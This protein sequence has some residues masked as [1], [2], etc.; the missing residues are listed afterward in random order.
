MMKRR[1]FFKTAGS[2]AVVLSAGSMLAFD[3]PPGQKEKSSA[4]ELKT[5]LDTYFAEMMAGKYFNPDHAMAGDRGGL[6][7]VKS[8]SLEVTT[9]K[10]SVF[11]I[12]DLV[13]KR[14][15]N[16]GF[17]ASLLKEGK[18]PE[19]LIVK[20]GLLNVP[21]SMFPIRID[22]LKNYDAAL[23]INECSIIKTK[24]IPSQW[25][26]ITALKKEEY[27]RG[28]VLYRGS[29]DLVITTKPGPRKNPVMEFRFNVDLTDNQVK[30][31]D[32]IPKMVSSD[33]IYSFF[34]QEQLQLI[35]F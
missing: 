23:S 7:I 25:K 34:T 17:D 30:I 11:D 21:G 10:N 8:Y 19:G 5:A 3:L 13:I 20:N 15:K 33:F 2:A 28:A 16:A 22:E 14:L 6:L 12:C 24:Q 26:S 29:P 35:K 32:F 4:E 18:I 31:I 27:P 9:E 1:E